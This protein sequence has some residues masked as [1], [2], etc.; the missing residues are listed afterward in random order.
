MR[1]VPVAFSDAARSVLWLAACNLVLLV[2]LSPFLGTRTSAVTLSVFYITL[3]F[4][5][6]ASGVAAMVAPAVP[7]GM[8]AAMYVL[9]CA[10][11]AVWLGRTPRRIDHRYRGFNAAAGTIVAVSAVM[12][13]LEADALSAPRWDRAVSAIS[14]N[15]PAAARRPES[16]PDIYYIVF[17]GLGR[18]D[19]LRQQYGVDVTEHIRT[20]E[21]LGWSVPRRSRANY[22]QTYLS[23]ASALNGA[24]L[25]EL[26]AVMGSSSNRRPLY[27]LIQRSGAI[28][29]L[30]H[31]GYEFALIGS[32][33]SATR[34]HRLADTCTCRWPGLTEFENGL[35]S[36]TPFAALPLYT[37]TFGS[38]RRTIVGSLDALDRV[39]GTARPVF[40][41]A[42]IMAPHPPF[43]VDRQGR[44]IVATG[45][46]LYRDGDHF[47][48]GTVSYRQ[49][50]R[51]QATFVLRRLVEFAG[52]IEKRD[53]R[54]LVVVHGDHG[55]G[56]NYSHYRLDPDG[57]AE[58]L[59]VFMAV[60]FPDQ[61]RS[62]PED[63]SPVNL[64]RVIFNAEFGTAYPLLPNRSYYSTWDEPYRLMEVHV[65]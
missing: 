36:M 60:R 27:E 8:A 31:M 13:V 30:K 5:P 4:Y 37:A 62:V 24:Y 51:E 63:L 55:P 48:G 11:A 23:L 49:G 53:R 61:R 10:A 2:G 65:R 22:P 46:V 50:Y 32:N 28:E 3:S 25:N 33:T 1:L 41:F 21:R 45:P 29:S 26:A 7:E 44:P 54:S 43:V 6:S 39:P 58:R 64:L 15:A 56:A 47:S 52:R 16:P 40:V 18:E 17:D 38:H 34:T 20:L 57:I 14:R 9:L 42:H 35:L 12:A 19:V 59:P